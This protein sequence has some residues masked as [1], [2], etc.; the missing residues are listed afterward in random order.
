MGRG[1]K[2][3]RLTDENKGTLS[4]VQNV[5]RTHA[6]IVEEGAEFGTDSNPRFAHVYDIVNA[7]PRHTFTVNSRLV[8]NCNFGFLYGMGAKKFK[9]FA[10]TDYG[11][12]YT[13]QESYETRDRFFTKY[14]QL[15]NWH[16]RMREEAHRCGFVQALHGAKRHLPS[17]RSSDKVTV[18]SS[19][20]QA[21]NSPVQRFGSDLGV[22]AMIRFCQ[23]ADPN[24]FRMIGFVHD[25]LYLEV[26]DGYE[27]EGVSALLWAMET[28]PL[29]EWFGLTPPIP[30]KAEADIGLNGGE[31]IEFADLPNIE[32]QPEWFRN[33][34]FTSVIS[35]KPDWWNDALEIGSFQEV[36]HA[37]NRIIGV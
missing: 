5:Y 20:R 16:N 2:H 33:L 24:L 29:Q 21:I 7:G 3:L 28:P 26:R 19:E 15:D 35:R 27:A 14:S 25:A 32:D 6:G 4:R 12:N 13:E 8:F 1:N 10:K 34:G 37:H 31:M 23:Q 11:V 9:N 17:I 18:G 36:I 22:I 30:I